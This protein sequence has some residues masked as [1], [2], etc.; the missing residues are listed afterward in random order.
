MELNPEEKTTVN[1]DKLAE[2]GFNFNYFTNTYTTRSGK[3]Y[4]FCYE[5]GYLPLD[6][7]KFALVLRKEYVS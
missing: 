4:Y 2:K 7:E 5:Q 3:T 6:G 1:R